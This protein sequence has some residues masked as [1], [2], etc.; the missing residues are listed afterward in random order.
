MNILLSVRI[1][2]VDGTNSPSQRGQLTLCKNGIFILNGNPMI[3][4][5]A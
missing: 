3:P 1:I 4:N 5:T 2:E